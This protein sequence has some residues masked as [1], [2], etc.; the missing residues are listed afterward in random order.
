MY[1]GACSTI[2]IGRRAQSKKCG[3][4]YS[5]GRKPKEYTATRKCFAVST[6]YLT[7]ENVYAWGNEDGNHL[8]KLLRMHVGESQISCFLRLD[9][10]QMLF[11]YYPR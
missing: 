10:E 9:F 11:F 1:W 6:S 2:F 7:K 4:C 5:R 3:D 8:L